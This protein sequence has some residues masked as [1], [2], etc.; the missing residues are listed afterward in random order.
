MN[1]WLDESLRYLSRMYRQMRSVVYSNF[2]GYTT[3]SMP[4]QLCAA[5]KRLANVH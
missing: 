5:P 3:P 4:K 2:M 1:G